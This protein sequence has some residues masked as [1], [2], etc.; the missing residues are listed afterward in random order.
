MSLEAPY[1]EPTIRPDIY[2]TY[3]RLAAERQAIFFRR[4]R[5]DPPPWTDDPILRVY[6]FCN[7][8]RA[9]DR[10][11]QFLI[12][13]VIYQAG[14][15]PEDTFCR[16]VLFRLFSKIATWELIEASH[17]PLT[18]RSFDPAVIAATLDAAMGRGETI[19]TNAF[20]LA[21]SAPFGHRRKHR[22]HLA[23]V[24]AMLRDGLPR[25]VANA[26]SLAAVY[27][28]LLDYPTIGP[29]LAYQL[30]I[31]L[32][33]GE[34]IDFDENDFTVPGPGAERGIRKCFGD[35]GSW[36]L[37]RIIHWMVERQTDEFARLGIPF[38]SL[39]GRPLH[40]IDCQ[41]LFCEL[42][43]YARV[44]FPELPSNRV[45]IKTRF[46]PRAAP[47]PCFYP[48]KWGLNAAVERSRD[49]PLTEVWC[50]R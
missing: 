17:G 12:R 50:P 8:Y 27:R 38:Q 47:I 49:A 29:F 35:T 20:I 37:S 28:L 40:A 39:W 7:A 9:S 32:N 26:R 44:A 36:S 41:N 31:D 22:N 13:D 42:D 25:Q 30:A 16:V 45:R 10:V 3:W 1:L 18:V 15:S 23:L 48:P 33:Y 11:S 4:L 21:A 5:G 2:E 46:A 14:Y 19:Y 24:E 43:K 6:K 34:L